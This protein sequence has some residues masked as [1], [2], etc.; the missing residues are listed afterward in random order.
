MSGCCFFF[1]LHAKQ[2]TYLEGA[3]CV[4]RVSRTALVQGGPKIMVH[5]R[6]KIRNIEQTEEAKM[7]LIKERMNKKKEDKTFVPT[8]MAV[9]FV[10]HNRCKFLWQNSQHTN[11]QSCIF[12]L[13][14]EQRRFLFCPV[15]LVLPPVWWVYMELPRKFRLGKQLEN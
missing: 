6:A 14:R 2:Q 13:S 10:Q 11:Q 7:R 9:N 5:C 12:C 8:N 3:V 4:F 15:C 1:L